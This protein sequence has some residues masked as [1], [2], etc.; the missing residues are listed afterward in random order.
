MVTHKI[1]LQLMGYEEEKNSIKDQSGFDTKIWFP[2]LFISGKSREKLWKTH[3]IS[4]CP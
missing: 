1:P 3:L 4:L 2:G